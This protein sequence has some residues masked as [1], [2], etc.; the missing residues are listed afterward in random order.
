MS[1][2]LAPVDVA[3]ARQL[4]EGYTIQRGRP[5]KPRRCTR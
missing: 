4:P 2:I 3:Q 5:D 1:P